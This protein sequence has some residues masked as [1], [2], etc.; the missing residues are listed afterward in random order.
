MQ[1][2]ELRRNNILMIMLSKSILTHQLF[3]KNQPSFL[4]QVSAMG[5]MPQ[6]LRMEPQEQEK[7]IQCLAIKGNLVSLL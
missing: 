7:H 6:F 3:L 4:F 1:V 2:L 5:I